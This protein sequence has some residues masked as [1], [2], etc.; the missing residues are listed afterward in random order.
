VNASL[1][2]TGPV[3]GD[4]NQGEVGDCYFMSSLAAF[5][6]VKPSVL[7]NSA[8]DMGDGTYVV[9]FMSGSTPTYVRV[10]NTF[11]TG[12]FAC[13]FLYA[14]PGASQ[15]IWASV[16]EKAF[17]EFRT[18]A[19]TYASIG[20]GWMSEVYADLGVNSQSFNFSSYNANTFY[21]LI[22]SDL[23]KG[24]AV[25]LAT[26][27]SPPNLVGDHAYTLL[28]TLMVN[29]IPMFTVRN[30][31]GVSGDSLENGQGQATLTFA[32]VVANFEAFTQAV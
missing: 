28:S 8:V 27:N 12:G 18:G 10:N 13:G 16:I 19:N 6:D 30:P 24:D 21:T 5:A 25:T 23:A 31:W 2:G 9:Q 20:G 1:F 26:P 32:Q 4:V 11:S 3:I 22:S 17:C 7:V 29:G 15:N 14:F